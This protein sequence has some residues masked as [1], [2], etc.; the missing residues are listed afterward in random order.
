MAKP[1]IKSVPQSTRLRNMVKMDTPPV[2]SPLVQSAPAPDNRAVRHRWFVGASMI[3]MPVVVKGEGSA[4]CGGNPLITQVN[5]V[6]ITGKWNMFILTGRMGETLLIDAERPRTRMTIPGSRVCQQRFSERIFPG[7]RSARHCDDGRD[8]VKPGLTR[9]T[10]AQLPGWRGG[11][12][13]S[14][15]RGMK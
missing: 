9:A 12:R 14:S 3:S 1:V 11:W 13:R 10:Q 2:Y 6:L 7:L 5:Q 8:K 4:V 15:D